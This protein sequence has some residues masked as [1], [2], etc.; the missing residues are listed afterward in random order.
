VP[1]ATT[2]A[3]E[4]R[5]GSADIAAINS[6]TPDMVAT[7]RQNHHLQVLEKP[8]TNLA[9]LAFNLRDPL[10]KDVRIRQA[11]AYAIDRKVM[12]HYL[13]GDA[14]KLADSVLP[15][16]H[17]AYYGDVVHYTLDPDK[18]NAILDAAGY[19]RGKDGVRFHLTMK[20]STEENTRLMAAVLQQQL[21][22]AGIALDIRSFE[23]STFYA[24]VIKGAFQLYSLRWIGYS[25]QDPDIFEY[26]FYTGSFAPKRGNRGYYSNPRV[27]RLIEEG[28]QTLDQEKRKAIY[29]EIQSILAQEL[30][31]IDFWYLDNVMV[32]STRVQNLD[33][34]SSGNY[35]FLRTVEVRP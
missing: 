21:R 7:L 25:N 3:L 34:S 12:L 33:I 5:K 23:F 29:A 13:W 15:P 2:R 32:H 35:D 8:G 28:R 19:K 14:G 10:L 26:A 16:Q 17:W 4:L 18:A 1:D 9:Y 30:P 11:L 22:K 6:M 24:D 20:T 27:D 31:Y